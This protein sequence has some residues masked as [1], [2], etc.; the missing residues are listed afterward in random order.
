MNR[1][2]ITYDCFTLRKYAVSGIIKRCIEETLASEGVNA[3]CEI[4]VLVTN[5]SGI[6]AINLASRSVDKPTDLRYNWEKK[7]F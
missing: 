7:N 1:I 5:D 4:N 2:K 6:R 3:D